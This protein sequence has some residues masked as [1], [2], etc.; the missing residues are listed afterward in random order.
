MSLL[1][2]LLGSAQAVIWMEN[3]DRLSG[4]IKKISGGELVLETVYGGQLRLPQANVTRWQ[5]ESGQ[6]RGPEALVVAV[7]P[8]QKPKDAWEY[9]ASADAS[10]K[11]KR[12]ENK[13]NDITLKLDTQLT[14]RQ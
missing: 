9:K 13:R 5:D 2:A 7:T 12:G 10:V 4:Q 1:L 14:A 3:G 11:L 8:P 6:L